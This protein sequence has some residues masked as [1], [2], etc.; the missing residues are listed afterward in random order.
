MALTSFLFLQRL[1]EGLQDASSDE[2]STNKIT[3]ST[4]ASRVLPENTHTSRLLPEHTCTQAAED[5]L[6]QL[7]QESQTG[8]PEATGTDEKIQAVDSLVGCYIYLDS[9]L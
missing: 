6:E 3:L 4:H 1:S 9:H 7:Q 2:G 8:D 5:S